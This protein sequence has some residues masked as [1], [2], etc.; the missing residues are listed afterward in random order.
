MR[1]IE[2]TCFFIDNG[3]KDILE[4]S[5][6]KELGE[7]FKELPGQAVSVSLLGLEGFENSKT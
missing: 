7:Q 5:A 2:V 1:G 6:L 4:I 3:E